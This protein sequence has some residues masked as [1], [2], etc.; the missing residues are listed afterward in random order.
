MSGPGGDGRGPGNRGPLRA[1][2][3]RWSPTMH[4]LN[5]Y[6]ARGDF[7]TIKQ[8]PEQMVFEYGGS[9]R[10]YTPGEHSVVSAEGGVADQTTGWKGN[11]YVI[12]IRAQEGPSIVERYGLADDHKHLLAKVRITGGDLG[13]INF[14]RVYEHTDEIAPRVLPSND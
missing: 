3:L 14:T 1:E 12:S 10:R 9:V 7:V 11:E 13:T 8:S 2:L 6:L 5:S 4:V